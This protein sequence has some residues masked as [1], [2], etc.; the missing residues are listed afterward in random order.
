VALGQVHAKHAQS[1][2]V[3]AAMPSGRFNQCYRDVLRAHG[4]ALR[5]SGTLHLVFGN[6]GH[7]GEA[8]FTGPSG[9]ESIGQ[10]IVGSVTG[11][12]VRNVEAGADGADIDLAFKPE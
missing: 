7:V 6:D 2:D 4:S 10:C 11:I 12:N 5:G 1:A 8:G 9:F 3:L